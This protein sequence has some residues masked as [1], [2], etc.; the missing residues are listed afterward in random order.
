MW[1]INPFPKQQSLY[2]ESIL[3]MAQYNMYKDASPIC[4]QCLKGLLQ[5][6]PLLLLRCGQ[7]LFGQPICIDM[8]A[9]IGMM[10]VSS[11]LAIGSVRQGYWKNME[12]SM[13]LNLSIY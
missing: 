1:F 5:I 11:Y 6:L 10:N 7:Y 4:L 13:R 2:T 9:V 12:D 8:T 3:S